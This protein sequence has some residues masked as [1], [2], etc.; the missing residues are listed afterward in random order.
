METELLSEARRC[1]DS[2]DLTKALSL[3]RDAVAHSPADADAHAM[4]GEVCLQTGSLEEA[5]SALLR[6]VELT[7]SG[8]A[9]R[10]MYLG[11]LADGPQSLQWYERGVDILRSQRSAAE[12]A[13]GEREELQARWLETTQ[14]L[15]I[16]LCAI[17][18]LYLSDLCFEA[19]AEERC[20]ALASEALGLV[21]PLEVKKRKKK[22]RERERRKGLGRGLF[23]DQP[24]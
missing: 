24:F 8:G 10:Y 23:A 19:D 3:C 9:G 4:L 15:A 22:K 13:S 16:G 6:S 21:K 20:E 14:A 1:L 11:Q 2:L 18:E 17:A 12:S 7:A 5:E